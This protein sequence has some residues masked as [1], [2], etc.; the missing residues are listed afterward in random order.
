MNKYIFEDDPEKTLDEIF[1]SKMLGKEV[2]YAIV[3]NGTNAGE[4]A[5]KDKFQVE[6]PSNSRLKF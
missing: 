1:G 6:I 3:N 4:A 5:L 2:Q